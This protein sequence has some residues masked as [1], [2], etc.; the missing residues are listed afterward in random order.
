MPADGICVIHGVWGRR[1]GKCKALMKEAD[2]CGENPL[3]TRWGLPFEKGK[4]MD[5]GR[6]ESG[7]QGAETLGEPFA[8]KKPPEKKKM[9]KKH[10]KR[11]KKD[12]DDRAGDHEGKE[13]EQGGI[14]G[15]NI[16]QS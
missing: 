11:K 16:G 8:Q 5:A 4:K 12:K 9:G 2:G 1:G 15:R 7:T 3:K 6:I 10:R 13:G 14:F